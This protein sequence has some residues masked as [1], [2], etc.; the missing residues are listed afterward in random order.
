MDAV[1]GPQRL[2]KADDLLDAVNNK[3]VTAKVYVRKDK[4]G[5]YG[6][7]NRIS[8]F[9]G[10]ETSAP[11]RAPTVSQREE[12]PAASAPARQPAAGNGTGKMAWRK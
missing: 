12:A 8:H 3:F 2:T 10:G 1:G 7:S 11:A 4:S 6:D 9:L 5:Q